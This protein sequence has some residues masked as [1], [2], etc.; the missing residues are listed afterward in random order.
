[1]A[2]S[3]TALTSTDT[4]GFT[5]TISNPGVDSATHTASAGPVIDP[6]PSQ[7]QRVA[8]YTTLGTGG[9]TKHQ[10]LDFVA[11]QFIPDNQTDGMGIQRIFT[12]A[13][14]KVL[15]T[16][17]TNTDVTRPTIETVSATAT[18]AQATFVVQASDPKTTIKEVEIFFT[19]MHGHL[20]SGSR[21]RPVLQWPHMD[22]PRRPHCQR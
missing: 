20:A 16:S 8:T 17:P 15:Y 10:E 9:V 6:F 12:S 5:P 2:C 19:P 14:V 21:S 11:G 3:S 13:K 22:R 7:L 4:D 18:S 1:M